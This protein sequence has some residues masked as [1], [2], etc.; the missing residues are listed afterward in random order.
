[1][2]RI[3]NFVLVATLETIYKGLVQPYF[4]YCTPLWDTCGRFRS[5]AAR[6]LTGASYDT[7]S[8]D[9]IDSLS[10]QTLDNRRCWAK[11]ILM[12]KILNDHTTP[13]LSW[14]PPWEGMSS[15]LRDT[16]TDLT[17]PKPKREFL[18]RSFKFSS[19]MLWN[20][21]PNK[22]KLAESTSSFKSL[23]RL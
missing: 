8:A 2:G 21:L 9:L 23:L 3:K 19:A 22:A 12:N 13:G 10:W 20:Q 4:E 17:L 7:S 15:H 5:S 11:S 16:D 14:T 18:K 6:V 1:M